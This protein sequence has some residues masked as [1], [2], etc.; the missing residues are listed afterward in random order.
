MKISEGSIMARSKKGRSQKT[1]PL[2][3]EQE[4]LIEIFAAPESREEVR[5]QQRKAFDELRKLDEE[6]GLEP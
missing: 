2:T 4:L 6:I 3:P 1:R 5:K